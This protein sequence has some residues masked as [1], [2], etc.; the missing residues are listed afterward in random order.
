MSLAG[1]P[2]SNLRRRHVRYA[3]NVAAW[4]AWHDSSGIRRHLMGR[5]IDISV[6]GAR[7]ELSS[8]TPAGMTVTVGIP[9]LNLTATSIVRHCQEI[10]GKFTLGVEFQKRIAMKS[11]I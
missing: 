3:G 2:V 4:V 8:A 11:P 6:S 7:L 9:R 1:R 10:G 5:C